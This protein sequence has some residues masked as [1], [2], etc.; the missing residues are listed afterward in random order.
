MGGGGGGIWVS[1]VTIQGSVIRDNSATNL[2]EYPS[3]S[4]PAH[5]GGGLV[6]TG[7]LALSE[8]LVNNNSIAGKFSRGGGILAMGYSVNVT[9]STVTVE[10]VW[11]SVMCWW[12]PTQ[13]YKRSHWSRL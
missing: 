3:F 13:V 12:N 2:D 8:S 11:W 10:Q 1:Y 5:G 6:A 7:R 9:G 4:F